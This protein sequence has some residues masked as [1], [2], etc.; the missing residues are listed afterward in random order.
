MNKRLT[1]IGSPHWMA[2]EVISCYKANKDRHGEHEED[3]YDNHCDVWSLGNEH[4][5]IE[6]Q[7]RICV[8][9]YRLIQRNHGY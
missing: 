3:G 9:L 2:P 7:S 4:F 5:L 1:S 6:S 8:M